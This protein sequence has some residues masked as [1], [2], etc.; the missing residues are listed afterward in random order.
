MSIFF[1]SVRGWIEHDKQNGR[2]DGANH[3]NQKQ[4][5]DLLI[6][7]QVG[8]QVQWLEYYLMEYGYKNYWFLKDGATKVLG[9]QKYQ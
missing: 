3:S 4:D 6:F 9:E 1:S 8:K 5:K 7:D 2:D